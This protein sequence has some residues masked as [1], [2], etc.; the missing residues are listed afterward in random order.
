MPQLIISD[1]DI[2]NDYIVIEDAGYRHIKSLRIKIGEQI[3]F[4]SESGIGY[5]GILERLN[6]RKAIFKIRNIVKDDPDRSNIILAQSI[7]KKDKMRH[8]LQKATELGVDTIIPFKSQYTIVKIKNTNFMSKYETI[9]KEGVGQSMR[10]SIPELHNPVSY[11]ELIM[12][13]PDVCKILF[14]YGDN[15]KPVAVFLEKI[16]QADRVMLIVGPEGGFS[17]EEIKLAQRYNVSI[18]NLGSNIFR[19]ETAAIVAIAIALFIR[20]C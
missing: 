13:M 16:K 17:N 18:A 20:S 15:V 12:S 7:I 5:V 14:H 6:K 10:H 3:M 8:A 2:N 1:N 4:R 19:S 11:E 9:I